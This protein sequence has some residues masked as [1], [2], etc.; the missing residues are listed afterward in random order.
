[1]TL[2]F[3]VQSYHKALKK[4][5]TFRVVTRFYY[6]ML[7]LICVLTIVVHVCS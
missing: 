5:T 4:S 6:A 1:M 7:V 2:L 3:L